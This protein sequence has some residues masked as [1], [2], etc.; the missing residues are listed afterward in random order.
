[1]DWNESQRTMDQEFDVAAVL[2]YN[3]DQKA[4]REA[5]SD[6]SC[7]AKLALWDWNRSS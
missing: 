6:L 1:M 4:P 7:S 3:C 5:E 2:T